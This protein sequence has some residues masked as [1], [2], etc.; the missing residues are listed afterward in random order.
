VCLAKLGMIRPMHL[1]QDI[2]I[3]SVVA[4][5]NPCHCRGLFAGDPLSVLSNDFASALSVTRCR[6]R[7]NNG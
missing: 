2:S 7:Q 5:F 1:V 3:I 4:Q 6:A